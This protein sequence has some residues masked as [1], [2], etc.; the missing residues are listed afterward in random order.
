MPINFLKKENFT[1]SDKGM[2][3]R[4]EKA[5][6]G[7]E[8]KLIV[9]AWPEPYGYAA[10]EDEKKDKESFPFTEEGI[11]AGVEWLNGEH[12]KFL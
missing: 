7:E 11:V 1:G 5:V 8:T 3:Y 2:R 6:D 9:T 10:T 4:M 12:P